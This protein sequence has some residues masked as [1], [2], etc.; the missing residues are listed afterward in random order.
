M[1]VIISELLQFSNCNSS[2]PDEDVF[3]KF[4]LCS[5]IALLASVAISNRFRIVKL[6][7]LKLIIFSITWDGADGLRYFNQILHA[8]QY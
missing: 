6:P 2:L 7:F 4:C 3:T 1:L 5:D 8:D